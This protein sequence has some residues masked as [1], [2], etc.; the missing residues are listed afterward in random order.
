MPK[1]NVY[2]PDD[3]ATAVREAGLSVSPTC[4]KALAEAVRVVG[5]AR[6]VVELL[7]DPQLD[8]QEHPEIV[9]RIAA[10]MTRHLRG[11]LDHARD[12]AGVSGLVE[13][14]HL[15]VGVIDEPDNLGTQV[16][17][18]LGVDI[19]GLRD[20]ALGVRRSHSRRPGTRRPR[21]APQRSGQVLG[22]LSLTGRLSIAAALEGAVDLRHDFL[23]CEHL[24]LGLAGTSAGAAGELLRDLGATSDAIRRVIPPTLA[25]VA[26]GYSNARRLSAPAATG[27]LDEIVRRLDE[28][29]ARLTAG[30][31]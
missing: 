4:Q 26:L 15:L 25:A 9:A 6:E 28:F 18:S 27:R 21:Q 3:L 20:A 14:E 24:V 22:G 11:A 17:R 29:E 10:R 2:L 31:L 8:P 19:A 12:V 23:G 1:I 16:L 30:G 13:T 7:R 5:S